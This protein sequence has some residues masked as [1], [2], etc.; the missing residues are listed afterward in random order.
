M[1]LTEAVFINSC[2]TF[3]FF[4]SSRAAGI[5]PGS[6]VSVSVLGREIEV[7]QGQVGFLRHTTHSP[8]PQVLH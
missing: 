2:Q 8:P 3:I 1:R 7:V 6:A 4:S 5:G